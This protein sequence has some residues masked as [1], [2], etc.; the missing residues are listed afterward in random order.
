VPAFDE[1]EWTGW[2]KETKTGL[3]IPLRPIS[4]THAGD[5]SNRTFLATQ[6]GVIHVLPKGGKGKTK[7]FLDIQSLVRYSDA[8]NEEGFLGLAFSP[9]YKTDGTFYVYYTPRGVRAANVVARYKVSKD[10]PDK[11]EAKSEEVLLT[12]KKPFWNHDGGTIVF[13]PDKMLYIAVG[14][15]GAADDPFKNGQNLNSLLG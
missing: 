10:D 9:N 7:V 5:G 15:G 2:V 14:D 8:T 4:L 1:V 12:L 3:S 13:G 11:A 6:H